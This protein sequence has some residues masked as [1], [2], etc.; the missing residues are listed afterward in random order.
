[1]ARTSREGDRVEPAALT[2]SSITLRNGAWHV[3]GLPRPGRHPPNQPRCGNQSQTRPQEPPTVAT[4]TRHLVDLDHRHTSSLTDAPMGGALV[5]P[6]PGTW[7]TTSSRTRRLTCA[8]RGTGLSYF[9]RVTRRRGNN[10]EMTGTRTPT[11]YTQPGRRASPPPARIPTSSAW[12]LA[13]PSPP[14]PIG[15]INGVSVSS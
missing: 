2:A 4:R 10:S 8:R 15:R 13:K 3:S 11:A 1:V 5:A 6:D 9:S 14:P 7:S 12:A